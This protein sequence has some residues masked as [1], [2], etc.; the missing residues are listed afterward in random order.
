MSLLNL[1]P[2]SWLR[3]VF[4]VALC[5]L[6]SAAP[7]QQQAEFVPEWAGAT[8]RW[9]D[10]AVAATQAAQVSPLR[11]EVSVGSLD[12]RLKLAPCNRIEP[13]LPPGA[14]LWGK[15]RLGVRCAD[16]G[17]RWS[18]FMPV[19][20]KAFGPAYVLKAH[21]APG[22]AIREGDLAETEVDWAEEASP[23]LANPAQWQNQVAARALAPGQTLR[24]N[25]LKAVQVFQAGAQV[26]VTAQGP[27]FTVTTD[28]QALTPGVVGQPARVRMDNGRIMSGT[29]LD[30]N[31]VRLEL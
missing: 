15:T 10:E 29:V 28:A 17:A 24:Q 27:G 22:A 21:L 8:Q 13:F 31:T 3:A 16:G 20:I 1:S 25:M 5:A 9:L 19:T 4:A 23:V 14:R 2:L 7:A 11:M 18:V 6:A 30:T 26:R 12:P